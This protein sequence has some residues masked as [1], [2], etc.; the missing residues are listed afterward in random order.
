VSTT[1]ADDYETDLLNSEFLSNLAQLNQALKNQISP[2]SDPLE[3]LTDPNPF[4][5]PVP[6]SNKS[7]LVSEERTKLPAT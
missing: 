6:K 4:R 2:R 1:K 3:I 5:T 7:N